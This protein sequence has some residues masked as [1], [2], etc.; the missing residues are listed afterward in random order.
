EAANSASKAW[1][2]FPRI[3]WPER[4]A[5]SAASSTSEF[6][7]HFDKVIF[8][9]KV[10]ANYANLRESILDGVFDWRS[11]DSGPRFV[12]TMRFL[13]LRQ[14]IECLKL[15]NDPFVG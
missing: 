4:M 9:I 3:Y 1:H 7:K 6:T 14:P 8:C 2:S 11:T 5:R 10:S 12:K 13:A 15:D